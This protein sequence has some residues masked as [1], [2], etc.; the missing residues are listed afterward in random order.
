MSHTYGGVWNS[1]RWVFP[2]LMVAR[3]LILRECL[4]PTT[5]FQ[6]QSSSNNLKNNN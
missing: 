2:N 5:V 3:W 6:A 4:L 1:V